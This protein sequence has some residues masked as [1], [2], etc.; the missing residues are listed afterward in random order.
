MIENVCSTEKKLLIFSKIG[1]AVPTLTTKTYRG[2][3]GI[4]PLILNLGR[5][6][7][8]VVNFMHRALYPLKETCISLNR[9]LGDPQRQSALSELNKNPFPCRNSKPE[10]LPIHYTIYTI[11]INK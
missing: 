5:K 6:R 1:K 2:S 4:A 7:T 3:R 9:R 8:C 10:S 11:Q